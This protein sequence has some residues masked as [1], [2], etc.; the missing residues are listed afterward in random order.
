MIHVLKTW[1][2]IELLRKAALHSMV[3][4][5]LTLIQHDVGTAAFM[6][7]VF[8]I[9][10]RYI[11]VCALALAVYTFVHYNAMPTSRIALFLSPFAAYAGLTTVAGVFGHIPLV[12]GS[13]Y[14]FIVDV[15]FTL[16]T[17]KPPQ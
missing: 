11:S 7:D 8:L 9:D 17:R 14:L 10:S 4:W 13:T 15:F 2:D 1:S 16:I 6:D 3:L 5:T 12:P